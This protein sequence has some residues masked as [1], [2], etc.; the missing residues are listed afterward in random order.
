MPPAA[1]KPRPPSA[2]GWCKVDGEVL[3][4]PSQT[5]ADGAAIEYSKPHPYVSRGGVK[6]AAALDHFDLSP[7]GLVCLDIGASTGGFTEVLLA[8]GAAQVY[9]VDVGHGQMHPRLGAR[10]AR[11]VC[12]TASMPAISPPPMCPRRPRRSS[13][14]SASSA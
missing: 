14:M 3:A 11:D 6:L 10:S 7:E 12:A 13:P 8:G 2:P 5:I 4:K 1:A 9:A